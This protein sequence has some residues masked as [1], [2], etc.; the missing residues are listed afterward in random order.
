MADKK[1]TR[2][3]S[4]KEREGRADLALWQGAGLESMFE[5]FFRPFDR[6]FQPLLPGMMRS[7]PLGAE[8]LRQPIL[9][10]KDR[11]DHYSLTAELPGFNK[12]EVE[13]RVDSSGIELKADKSEDAGKQGDSSYRR[14]TRSYY[15]YV[16]LPDHVLSEK[17]DGTMK[18]GILEL[19]LPKR[20][21]TRADV[22]RVDLK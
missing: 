12:D 16:S 18:N 11:G 22:R 5:E 15:Q 14:S 20:R 21:V 19:K 17:V 8:G 1:L 3:P 10:L 9:D 7:F 6:L 13:V 2:P 4:D